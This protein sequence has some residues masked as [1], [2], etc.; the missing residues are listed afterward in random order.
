LF[1]KTSKKNKK[2][3]VKSGYMFFLQQNQGTRGEWGG[4]AKSMYTH[5]SKCKNN[6]IKFKKKLIFLK[7][8]H[9]KF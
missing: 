6:K 8:S 3:S 9:Y 4:V 7:I 5:V 2:S 1:G